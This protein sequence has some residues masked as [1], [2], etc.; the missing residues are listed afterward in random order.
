MTPAPSGEAQTLAPGDGRPPD[1]RWGTPAP[2]PSTAPPPIVYVVAGVGVGMLLLTLIVLFVMGRRYW[3]MKPRSPDQPAGRPQEMQY[4]YG[5]SRF[6][7]VG[8]AVDS[9]ASYMMPDPAGLAPGDMHRSQVSTPSTQPA[10]GLAAH[11]LQALAPGVRGGPPG[12]SEAGSTAEG[13]SVNTSATRSSG[14]TTTATTT[15]HS[16]GSRPVSQHTRFS[17]QLATM[18]RSPPSP[19]RDHPG[20]WVEPQSSSER[21][22]RSDPEVSF[23]RRSSEQLL[24]R[25]GSRESASRRACP[26]RP[27]PLVLT[28]RAS[29]G[30]MRRGLGTADVCSPTDQSDGTGTPHE[31][32][33][34]LSNFLGGRLGSG[35]SV[36]S[37]QRRESDSSSEGASTSSSAAVSR[38][39]AVRTRNGLWR[40]G[41]VSER[42]GDKVLIRYDVAGGLYSH[43]WIDIAVEP[44]R[45]PA[46]AWPHLYGG[47]RAAHC[48]AVAAAVCV[49]LSG[50]QQRGAPGGADPDVPIPSSPGKRY[51]A[52]RVIGRGSYGTVHEVTRRSDGKVF[53]MKY[54]P[55][56]DM[57]A[58]DMAL[59][60]L[61]VLG[62]VGKDPHIIELVD[63]YVK[64]TGGDSDDS[65]HRPASYVCLVM[66][67]YA[68]GDLRALCS[69]E[70]GG[71]PTWHPPEDSVLNIA[72]QLALALRHLHSRKPRI[73]HRDLKPDN[74]LVTDGGKRLVVADFGLAR[75]KHADL[76]YCRTH[77]GTLVFSAPEMFQ[78]HY[79]TEVD[80]WA[81]G[82]IVHA[83]VL[84]WVLSSDV[85]VRVLAMECQK[86]KFLADLQAEIKQAG[87][88]E[89]L[90]GL[91]AKL[92]QPVPAERLS[93]EGTLLEIRKETYK[94]EQLKEQ[95]IQVPP[96][97]TPAGPSPPPPPLLRSGR[98]P[99]T[100][101]KLA[102]VGQLEPGAPPVL[103]GFGV[104]RTQFGTG[105][106][107]EDGRRSAKQV[108]E[109]GSPIPSDST[110]G[111]EKSPR[112]D[113]ASL[114]ASVGSM[115][116]AAPSF[117][118][119]PASTGRSPLTQPPSVS[120]DSRA[121]EHVV[122]LPPRMSSWP[123]SASP[124]SSPLRTSGLFEA[125][126]RQQRRCDGESTAAASGGGWGQDNEFSPTPL[127]LTACSPEHSP[128]VRTP[129]ARTPS[130]RS[131][132]APPAGSPTLSL[133]SGSMSPVLVPP[134]ESPTTP[135]QHPAA[136]RPA[137]PSPLE[138]PIEIK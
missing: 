95:Q 92:L 5:P 56:R 75:E 40:T 132:G 101:P 50:M 126:G 72:R 52:L 16:G 46:L 118:L 23:S 64:W 104:R 10:P 31:Y 83:I 136:L 71:L 13:R 53:A 29:E 88:S 107:K 89:F 121:A 47:L 59:K 27:T 61:H 108:S 33:V 94:K 129:S 3:A 37:S 128:S 34:S 98:E 57:R 20:G 6:R 114:S 120:G 86:P 58:R 30:D 102:A 96:S 109:E 26:P 105:K 17:P 135:P 48:A 84:G 138:S 116:S 15:V 67:Y 35:E 130:A 24:T 1:W 45:L 14:A 87:Y 112:F 73:L 60:E 19:L 137:N 43:E 79:G 36:Y 113:C 44:E 7:T 117:V 122:T 90:V 134:R 77:A 8:P 76:D 39:T 82:C 99:F 12:Q 119:S 65:G 68:D 111:L 63:T 97:P 51:Q 110:D 131:S 106:E 91:M 25:T 11:H 123:L 62:T 42:V 81:L 115:I 2:P 74:V 127:S 21:F 4:R 69:R 103:G 22:I 38:P 32:P 80:L 100:T 41:C 28:R 9:S 78:R 93:A 55:C 125:G 124:N 54:I 133:Q 70:W 18:R 85:P 66:P 49:A